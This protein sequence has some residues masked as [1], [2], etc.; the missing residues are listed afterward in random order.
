MNENQKKF[1]IE[2]HRLLDK[3]SVDDIY[4][5]YHGSDKMYDR[6][7]IVSNGQRLEFAGYSNDNF[8]EVGTYVG[9][10]NG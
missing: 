8:I 10:Y 4:I 5:S 3:Y 7:T 9:D 2:L 1:L 6:I